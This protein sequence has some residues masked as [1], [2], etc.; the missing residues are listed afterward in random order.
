MRPL[1]D[2]IKASGHLRIMRGS[3]A[4]EGAV[5]KITGKEGVEFSGPA[6]VFDREEA[7]LAALERNEILS[8]DVGVIRYEGPRGGPGMPEMLR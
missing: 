8:G 4:P 3:M 6:R 7:A 2:P 5:A 1:S